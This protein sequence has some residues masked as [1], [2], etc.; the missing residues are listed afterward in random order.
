MPMLGKELLDNL[1][2]VQYVDVKHDDPLGLV[3]VGQSAHRRNLSNA[4]RAPGCPKIE[5]YRMP[6]K[7]AQSHDIS[8]QIP[9]RKIRRYRHSVRCGLPGIAS[10]TK[11][12]HYRFDYQP[13]QL[14]HR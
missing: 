6:S 5:N 7:A 12:A 1:L 9:E 8:M 11:N 13:G 2:L 4:G 14:I 10:Q 3:L